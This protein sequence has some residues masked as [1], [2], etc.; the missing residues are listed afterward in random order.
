MFQPGQVP[1][2]AR[3]DIV[4]LTATPNGTFTARALR[5]GVVVAQAELPYRLDPRTGWI[6]IER[7][8]STDASKFGL[9]VG[10]MRINIAFTLPCSSW[11]A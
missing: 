8:A 7:I 1:R 5:Q 6:E 2:S 9:L 11:A 4:E 3:P 10:K